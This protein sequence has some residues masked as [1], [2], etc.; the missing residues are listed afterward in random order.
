MGLANPASI[1]W[2]FMPW[3][4]AVDWA[5]PI[6]SWI[7]AQSFALRAKGT[8]VYTTLNVFERRCAGAWGSGY[9]KPWFLSVEQPPGPFFT[10]SVTMTRTISNS[11][12]VPLPVFKSNLLG[13][14]PLARL[15]NAFS[16]LV[17]VAN[18]RSVGQYGF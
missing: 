15:A 14:E 16:L 3:S 6:G 2:E 9:S 11:I 13:G 17:G 10:K 5:I 1:A 8:F 4:F 18:R 7:E 12:S